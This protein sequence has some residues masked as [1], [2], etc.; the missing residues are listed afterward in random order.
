MTTVALVNRENRIWVNIAKLIILTELCD[1]TRLFA[2]IGG[3]G[4]VGDN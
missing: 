4:L 1:C 3:V 2:R